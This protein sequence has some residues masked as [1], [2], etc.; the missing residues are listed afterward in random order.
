LRLRAFFRAKYYFGTGI[1]AISGMRHRAFP[2]PS[3]PLRESRLPEGID[4]VGRVNGVPVTLAGVTG[5]GRDGGGLG[6]GRRK[7]TD[8][9]QMTSALFING[10]DDAPLRLAPG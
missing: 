6:E 5:T 2:S 9:R 8:Q 3:N 7:K 10:I 4:G 1:L